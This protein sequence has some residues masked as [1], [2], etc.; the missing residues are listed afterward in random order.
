[1]STQLTLRYLQAETP[2][3]LPSGSI[4]VLVLV[5]VA[6][7]ILADTRL[8]V[9]ATFEPPA[10]QVVGRFTGSYEN[11]VPVYRLPAIQIAA[12]RSG[13]AVAANAAAQVPASR[14]HP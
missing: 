4:L 13:D 2:Y 9:R 1:M 8:A 7:L 3:A 12:T 5:A 11:G 10:V 14:P 6:A